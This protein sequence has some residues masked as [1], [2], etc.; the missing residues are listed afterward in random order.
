MNGNNKKAPVAQVILMH[1]PERIKLS[2]K[3]RSKYWTPL[4]DNLPQK[5]QKAPYAFVSV[6]MKNGYEQR[7][8]NTITKEFVIKNA[9]TAGTP[10]FQKIN[11]QAIWVG[12][13]EFVRVK[14][15]DQLHEYFEPFLASLNPA[16]IQ[17]PKD[18]YLHLEYIF[19]FPFSSREP[20]G[21]Q[22]YFNH[23]MPYMK[24]FE[25]TL[26]K[27]GKIIN[28]SPM[29]IR[30]AYPRY[31][32]IPTDVDRRLVVQFYHCKNNETI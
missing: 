21:W 31:V 5:Y 16:V 10:S 15:R 30:G 24:T 12:M 19:Y 20:N 3:R 27:C 1:Y 7:M 17:P 4:D 32:G 13:N 23:A 2:D 28:D 11:G 25:D 22:D 26:V 29:I 6:K 14:L 18:H 9:R 8:I